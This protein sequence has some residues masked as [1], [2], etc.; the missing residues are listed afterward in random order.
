MTHLIDALCKMINLLNID[1]TLE[2]TG[3]ER[4]ACFA[5]C[6][7]LQNSSCKVYFLNLTLNGDD[8]KQNEMIIDALSNRKEDISSS[9]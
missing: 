2:E 3:I 1:L 6:N 9:S 7:V 5:L 4:K 8:D